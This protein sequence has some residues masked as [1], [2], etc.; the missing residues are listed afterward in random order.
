MHQRARKRAGVLRLAVVEFAKHRQHLRE[1]EPITARAVR[2][3]RLCVRARARRGCLLMRGKADVFQHV[4]S[5]RPDQRRIKPAAE[6]TAAAE[7][8]TEAVRAR[9]G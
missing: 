7:G 1:G 4:D 3:V 2:C 8:P 9:L 5:P 6:R